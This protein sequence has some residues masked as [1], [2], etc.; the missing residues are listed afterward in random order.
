MT[1][2]EIK[3]QIWDKARKDV[4]AVQVAA[5]KAGVRLPITSIDDAE[6]VLKAMTP[7]KKPPKPKLLIEDNARYIEANKAHIKKEF[8]QWYKDGH[9]YTPDIP[10]TAT[11]NGLQEFICD[12]IIWTGGRATRISSAGRQLNGKFIPSTTRKGSSDVSST[13]NGKSVM[14]EIKVG[15]DKPSPA[16]LKEQAKE[17]KAGGEYFFTH[18]VAEFFQQY[19]SLCRQSVIFD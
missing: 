5:D 19:H 10:N 16:Q 11:A 2:Q 6:A 14:W 13:I 12:Y 4:I 18:N 3:Q 7:R 15:K 1:L 17:R 9:W 8:P